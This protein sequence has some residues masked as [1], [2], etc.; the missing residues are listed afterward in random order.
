MNKWDL[1]KGQ[2]K[3]SILS[4][5]IDVQEIMRKMWADFYEEAEATVCSIMAAGVPSEKIRLSKP[6]MVEYSDRES[7]GF[8]M[9][10][11]SDITFK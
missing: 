4:P 5:V 1:T 10:I 9:K 11:V 6:K 7:L 2:I 3:G 8:R